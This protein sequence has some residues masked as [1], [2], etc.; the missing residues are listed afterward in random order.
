MHKKGVIKNRT[1][2][3]QLLKHALFEQSPDGN[4]ELS[5]VLHS[6]G[7]K[8]IILATSAGMVIRFD[9]KQV[10]AMGRTSRGVRAIK[11]KPMIPWLASV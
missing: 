10:R 11:I 2:I 6:N 5:W 4:D 9:E 1:I 3:I 8:D 7:E